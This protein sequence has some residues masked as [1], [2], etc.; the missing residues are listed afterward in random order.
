M[1]VEK[2]RILFNIKYIFLEKK[3]ISFFELFYVIMSFYNILSVL[4][5]KYFFIENDHYLKEEK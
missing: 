2:M 4:S 1:Y 5:R 3:I